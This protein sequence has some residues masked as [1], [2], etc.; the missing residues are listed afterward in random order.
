MS[1]ASASLR[2]LSAASAAA[3]R[4]RT[5]DS[6]GDAPEDCANGETQRLRGDA[7]G[8]GARDIFQTPFSRVQH[9]PTGASLAETKKARSLAGSGET[10]RDGSGQRLRIRRG[11]PR[12]ARQ[13]TRG[14]CGGLFGVEA[15]AEGTLGFGDAVCTEKPLLVGSSQGSFA[16]EVFDLRALLEQRQKPSSAALGLGSCPPELCRPFASSASSPDSATKGEQAAAFVPP[17]LDLLASALLAKQSATASRSSQSAAPVSTKEAQALLALVSHFASRASSET[18]SSPGAAK[19]E[20][21]E[22]ADSPQRQLARQLQPFLLPQFQHE[23][24]EDI[25][26]LI[27]LLRLAVLPLPSGDSESKRDGTASDC[28]ALRRPSKTPSE[29]APARVG[30]FPLLLV[31]SDEPT[32]CPNVVLAFS[33]EAKNPTANLEQL[34]LAYVLLA[35][36]APSS[37]DCHV[38]GASRPSSSPTA[39]VDARTTGES[40]HVAETAAGCLGPDLSE[41]A[42]TR[43]LSLRVSQNS[44]LESLYA[45]TF[46]REARRRR[47]NLGAV[48]RACACKRCT[49][50]PELCR[51]FNCQSCLSSD[52]AAGKNANPSA[53]FRPEMPPIVCPTSPSK[54]RALADTPMQCLRCGK[55]ASEETK[56]RFEAAEQS[57]F[58]SLMTA[59]HVGADARRRLPSTAFDALAD[60]AVGSDAESRALIADSHF[61]RVRQ[62]TQGLYRLVQQAAE[63]QTNRTAAGPTPGLLARSEKPELLRRRCDAVIQATRSVVGYHPDEARLLESLALVTGEEEDFQRA[64]RRRQAFYRGNARQCVPPYEVWK[65][66]LLVSQASSSA[67][68]SPPT[69][70]AMRAVESSA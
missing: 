52:A 36:D 40:T 25:E 12:P 6:R 46:M 4:R 48:S 54:T 53:S 10:E 30:F 63:R 16:A 50:A 18:A 57:L 34:N 38:P 45:P 68:A 60:A 58:M 28:R 69:S 29:P 41:A 26:T 21:G 64:Y 35:P 24:E 7:Y 59:A 70:D 44:S 33:D 20:E 11:A 66:R 31:L 55:E 51:S 43:Q 19:A 62:F 49:R 47:R 1:P 27:S 56:K 22:G 2:L 14:V 8:L 32:C 3:W 15:V 67:A 37:S 5:R 17:F 42:V 61:L 9:A 13:L 39:S 23:S 65:K